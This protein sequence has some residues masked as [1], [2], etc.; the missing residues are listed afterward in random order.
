MQ[1][2]S[3]QF[4]ILCGIAMVLTHKSK[5]EVEE[6]DDGEQQGKSRVASKRK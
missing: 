3:G 2:E 4:G 1:Q 6:W 5:V